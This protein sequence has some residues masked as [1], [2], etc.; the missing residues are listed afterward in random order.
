MP[1][2]CRTC[3]S[4]LGP[5][6]VPLQY[7]IT[8][9]SGN[10]QNLKS[11]SLKL[12]LSLKFC[13]N[14]HFHFSLLVSTHI[15]VRNLSSPAPTSPL[16]V[17]LGALHYATFVLILSPPHPFFVVAMLTILRQSSLTVN[18]GLGVRGA[19]RPLHRCLVGS[20]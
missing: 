13:K 4:V 14:R 20:L 18:S 5:G 10:F 1:S 3:C 17:P 11:K 12:K 2:A 9:Y 7:P 19:C 16:P 15:P 6:P 8:I